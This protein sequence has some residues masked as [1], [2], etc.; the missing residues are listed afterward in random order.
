MLVSLM[1][2]VLAFPSALLL[3]SHLE[4]HTRAPHHTFCSGTT[5]W[6]RFAEDANH[7]DF[8]PYPCFCAVFEALLPALMWACRKHF[9]IKCMQ[10]V[11]LISMSFFQNHLACN[12]K[13][14]QDCQEASKDATWTFTATLMLKLWED[15]WSCH[16]NA[17]SQKTK[18]A[19][20]NAW[21]QTVLCLHHGRHFLPC[22]CTVRSSTVPVIL[23][24]QFKM[25][26]QSWEGIEGAW[27]HHCFGNRADK[28]AQWPGKSVKWGN[29]ID[30][31]WKFSLF[32]HGWLQ[33]QDSKLR[34]SHC[35]HMP[36]ICVQLEKPQIDTAD[37]MLPEC[38]HAESSFWGWTWCKDARKQQ[39]VQTHSHAHWQPCFGCEHNKI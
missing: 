19:C 3:I 35:S 36:L 22:T 18:V 10:K 13:H 39:H 29:W 34:K 24:Q 28:D 32:A 17:E 12:N 6:L 30:V 1:M 20:N 21:Q 25:T 4:W 37:A 31:A 8:Q 9:G 26:I 2:M 15:Q 5:N 7:F 38:L 16:G 27:L 11:N 33:G 23:Q 14:S